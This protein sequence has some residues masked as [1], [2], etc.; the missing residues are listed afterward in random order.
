DEC[1]RIEPPRQGRVIEPRAASEIVAPDG[2]RLPTL[3]SDDT[4]EIPPAE[5]RISDGVPGRPNHT[6]LA[7][8][9]PVYPASDELLRRIE[10]RQGFVEPPVVDIDHAAY[11][12]DALRPGVRRE[13]SQ[14]L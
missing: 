10:C 4:V 12:V 13:E 11:I 5:N 6:A 14:V 3:H 2:D 9:Q 8:R 1:I 7:E